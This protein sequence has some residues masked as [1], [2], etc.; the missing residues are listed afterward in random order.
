MSALLGMIGLLGFV[1]CL[2]ILIVKAIRRKPKK[3][4]AILL[5][6]FFLCFVVALVTTSE[7]TDTETQEVSMKTES[8]K[9]SMP[10]QTVN[11]TPKATPVPKPTATPVPEE[12]EQERLEREKAEKEEYISSCTEIAY[13]KLLRTPDDYIGTQIVLTVKISQILNGWF[14]IGD[15]AYHCYTDES[16]YGWY[17]DD[18]YYVVDERSDKSLKLLEDDIVKIYGE[19]EGI[20][21]VTRAITSTNVEVPRVSMRY[22]ELI[23]E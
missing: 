19:Y 9:H 7:S 15:T 1:I 5:G 14:S 23:E 17:Y 2:V 16:G 18:E 22:V 11:P 20:E 12:A 21:T 3:V 10:V 4:C 8:E 6:V 13:K